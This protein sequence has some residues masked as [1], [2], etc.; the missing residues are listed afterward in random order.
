MES[1]SYVG[2]PRYPVFLL[3]PPELGDRSSR[4]RK[5]HDFSGVPTLYMEIGGKVDGKS[6]F[7]KKLKNSEKSKIL[8]MYVFFPI[9][10]VL[11][12]T[13]IRW[14]SECFKF[15]KNLQ[16]HLS[17]TS[18][19]IKNG[20]KHSENHRIEVGNK[21]GKKSENFKIFI[22][23]QFLRFLENPDFPSTFPPISIYKV[24]TP[25]NHDFFYFSSSY[26]RAGGVRRKIVY[27]GVPT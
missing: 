7:S 14:F 15:C 18:R 9:F 22:F 21:P 8:K 20:L 27:L 26:L 2:T 6:G 19:I 23:P 17:E 3:T 10:S 4:S 24:G 16:T 1:T 13:S 11:L 25:K 12:P 5:S